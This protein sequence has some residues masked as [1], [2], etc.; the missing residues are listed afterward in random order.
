MKAKEATRLERHE[1]SLARMAAKRADHR[2][3]H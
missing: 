3:R 2:S 1:R